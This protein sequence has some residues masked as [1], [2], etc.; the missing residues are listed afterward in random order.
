MATLSITERLKLDWTDG[1]SESKILINNFKLKVES[2]EGNHFLKNY[3]RFLTDRNSCFDFNLENENSCIKA[4][5]RREF[6]L[7]ISKE[8]VL[9]LVNFFENNNCIAIKICFGLD[10]K[11]K[12][13]GRMQLIVSGTFW[14]NN[15][16][17]ESIE[18]RLFR[19]NGNVPYFHNFD[20]EIE[21]SLFGLYHKFL[22]E[23]VYGINNNLPNEDKK[24]IFGYVISTKTFKSILTK[25][26]LLGNADTINFDLGLS[27]FEYGE[28]EHNKLL[29]IK[30]WSSQV[31]KCSFWLYD[32]D[33]AEHDDATC[34]PREPC[35]PLPPPPSPPEQ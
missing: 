25:S 7:T 14:G 24:A 1:N 10:K 11:I 12:D 35:T 33:M 19:V 34:P 16:K 4:L 32:T 15:A 8:K 9:D 20:N 21:P 23:E 29:M 26:S 5:K 6:R 31:K 13:G 18:D 22:S 27:Y 28:P 30:I 2:G 17:M 3:K